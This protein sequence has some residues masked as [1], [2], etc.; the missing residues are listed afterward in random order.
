MDHLKTITCLLCLEDVDFT[1]NTAY[2]NHLNSQHHIVYYC[3]FILMINLLDK[4][5]VDNFSNMIPDSNPKTV[6][7]LLCQ[8][9]IIFSDE[10][11]VDQYSTHLRNQHMIISN[12]QPIR[13]I[14]LMDNQAR[15][16][17]VKTFEQ[18]NGLD[19]DDDHEKQAN[20]SL[21][22]N[23]NVNNAET[24]FA[25]NDSRQLVKNNEEKM[26]IEDESTNGDV[27]AISTSTRKPYT[28][29]I[30]DESPDFIQAVQIEIDNGN[31][32]T[33]MDISYENTHKKMREITAMFMNG[34]SCALCD[35]GFQ[36]KSH[37][38]EH[39]ESMHNSLPVYFCN[40]CLNKPMTNSTQYR[41]HKK[42]CIRKV[43]NATV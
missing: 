11:G 15:N 14:N 43:K 23:I 17:I 21:D 27:G 34:N 5:Y 24:I 22:T 19:E 37:L 6:V 33:A 28:K 38:H 4:N 41:H 31:L 35:R 29:K 1:L 8:K 26:L 40:L 13:S 39:I 25:K 7:C 16:G 10:A 32:S 12:Q 20:S 18:I 9:E 30:K 36:N 42:V 2:L 3:H